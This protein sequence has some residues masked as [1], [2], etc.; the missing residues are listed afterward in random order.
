MRAGGRRAAAVI[1]NVAHALDTSAGGQVVAKTPCVGYTAERHLPPPETMKGHEEWDGEG[2]EEQKMHCVLHEARVLGHIKAAGGH[3]NVVVIRG[4]RFLVDSCALFMAK[5]KGRSLA[6]ASLPEPMGAYV[7]ILNS[8]GAVAAGIALQERLAI[9][10]QLFEAVAFIHRHSVVYRDMKPGNLVYDRRSRQL[11]V[12]DFGSAAVLEGCDFVDSSCYAAVT[13]QYQ[14]PELTTSPWRHLHPDTPPDDLMDSHSDVWVAAKMNIETEL[15]ESR[16]R[17]LLGPNQADQVMS[18]ASGRIVGRQAASYPEYVDAEPFWLPADGMPPTLPAAY[19]LFH[20]AAQLLYGPSQPDVQSFKDFV[21]D[22]WLAGLV[23]AAWSAARGERFIWKLLHRLSGLISFQRSA[24]NVCR[25]LGVPVVQGEGRSGRR[26]SA[27]TGEGMLRDG[28]PLQ[29][30]LMDGMRGRRNGTAPLVFNVAHAHDKMAG[31][32]VVK[33]TPCRAYTAD[34]QP[35]QGS[36]ADD[37]SDPGYWE[38]HEINCVLK[39]ARVLGRI[40][41]E[42]AGMTRRERLAI[43]T[44]LLEAVAHMHRLGMV[45]RDMK[46]DNVVYDRRSRQ[47]TVVEFGSAAVLEGCDFVD[48]S[49]S[50]AV[51]LQYQPP[52]LIGSPWGHLQPDAPPDGLM[53]MASD[54]WMVAKTAVEIVTGHFI[55][56]GDADDDDDDGEDIEVPPTIPAP[57]AAL[58]AAAI[59]KP[60]EERPSAHQL[61]RAARQAEEEEQKLSPW[62]SPSA[63]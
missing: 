25:E 6:E 15:R 32:V 42:Q 21:E 43:V 40:V 10:W 38:E 4:P 44:Q 3:K 59:T 2:W 55:K 24:A 53:N 57:L 52:E 26:Y 63:E 8:K 37:E 49:G 62:G 31:G 9:N 36:M 58:L 28:E 46:P 22:H 61:L 16:Y 11:T 47:L 18:T 14:S 56:G 12:V 30:C 51:T 17:R 7:Q 45:Y 34:R 54:I 50:S 19:R 23:R 27:D 29:Q 5:A 48:I 35:P 1:C 41:F 60:R 39:E 33:K 20:E 13:P